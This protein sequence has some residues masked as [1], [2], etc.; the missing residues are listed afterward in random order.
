[1]H[2]ALENLEGV[3]VIADDIL[4]YGCGSD[5]KEARINHDHNL[6]SLL[7]RCR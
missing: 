5:M 1:M 3:D 2:Q 4:V 7:E 6:K